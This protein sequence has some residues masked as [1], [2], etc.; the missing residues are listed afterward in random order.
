M[1]SLGKCLFRFSAHFL[2]GLF[3]FLV[4]SCLCI[5]ETNSLSVVSSEII[6]FY[7]EDCLLI[8]FFVSFAVKKG[9]V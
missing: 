8:L 5:L 7:S 1:S 2:V 9:F 6:F 4:L 3:V